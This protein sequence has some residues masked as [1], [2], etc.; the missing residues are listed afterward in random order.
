MLLDQEMLQIQNRYQ[1]LV[2]QV[3]DIYDECQGLYQHKIL[4]RLLQNL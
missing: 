2:S 3:R 4:D 1:M